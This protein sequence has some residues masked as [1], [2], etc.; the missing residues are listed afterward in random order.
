MHPNWYV[1]FL[2]S[3]LVLSCVALIISIVARVQYP[4]FG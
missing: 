2:D 4:P 3:A 1:Y